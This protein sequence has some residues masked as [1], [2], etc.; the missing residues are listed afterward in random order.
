MLD[1]YRQ[2]LIS[3]IAMPACECLHLRYSALFPAPSIARHD[4]A[5]QTQLPVVLHCE[6][7]QGFKIP[8]LVLSP[9]SKPSSASTSRRVVCC[10]DPNTL[11]LDLQWTASCCESAA[12]RSQLQTLLETPWD[13]A[14]TENCASF[15]LGMNKLRKHCVL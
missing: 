9:A 11:Q 2:Q 1:A 3:L 15:N 10:S 7:N 13:G 8:P 12:S 5:L 14:G 4:P 6:P